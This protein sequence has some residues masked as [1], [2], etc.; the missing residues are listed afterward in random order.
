MKV[1]IVSDTHGSHSRLEKVIE[2]EKPFDMLLHLGD[3]EGQEDYIEA[4]VDCP[5]KIVKGNN[6]FYSD[7]PNELTVELGNVKVYMTHGHMH[8]VYYG[9]AKI[10]QMARGQGANVALYGHTHM[11][12]MERQKHMLI[13]SPGSIE[14]PRQMGRR[15]SYAVLKTNERGVDSA[16]IFHL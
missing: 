6:D 14:Y 13:L 12:A 7:L 15:P 1:L 8:S 2:K 16:E 11:P 5:V 4:L 9:T 3:V 10:E